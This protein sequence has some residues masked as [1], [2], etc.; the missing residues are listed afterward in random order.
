M[1]F[2][3]KKKAVVEKRD[4]ENKATEYEAYL[5]MKDDLKEKWDTRS[6]LMLNFMDHVCGRKKQLLDV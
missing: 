4:I 3:K 1:G 2:S 6:A 5:S